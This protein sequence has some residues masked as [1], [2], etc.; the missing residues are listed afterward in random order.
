MQHQLIELHPEID[1]LQLIYGSPELMPVYGAGCFNKPDVMFIFMNPTGRNISAH[2]TWTGLRAP[3]LGTKNIWKL[4]Y[5]LKLLSSSSYNLTQ[6][7]RAEEWTESLAETIYSELI[8]NKVYITNLAKCTQ[9]NARPL[10][11]DIFK[12]Y[13]ENTR[14]EISL[15]QPKKI[16]SFGNQVSSI[17]LDKPIVVSKYKGIQSEILK[18]KN[19][20][21][22]IYPVYYPVGQGQRNMPMAIKRMKRILAV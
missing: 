17:I 6:S 9:D 14:K 11:D 12:K 18:I 5:R 3:W 13:L 7:L 19:S 16:V 15:I 8:K 1:R 22:K 10:P 21:F 20:S 4:L 2:A